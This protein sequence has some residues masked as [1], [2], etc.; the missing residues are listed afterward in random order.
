MSLF[1]LNPALHHTPQIT[2][3]QGDKSIFWSWNG[4]KWRKKTHFWLPSST[5]TSFQLCRTQENICYVCTG[6]ATWTG[7]AAT[8]NILALPGECTNIAVQF[9]HFPHCSCNAR[10]LLVHDGERFIT[11]CNCSGARPGTWPYPSCVIIPSDCHL[12][13]FFIL[14]WRWSEVIVI[15]TLEP[16]AK[17]IILYVVVLF[18]IVYNGQGK[19]E[20]QFNVT[21]NFLRY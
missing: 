11:W 18:Q 8:G 5:L 13:I 2:S 1:L 19:T 7:R 15:C 17:R 16:W 10:H 20:M 21:L 14:S 12:W 4:K 6:L 3:S 9:C